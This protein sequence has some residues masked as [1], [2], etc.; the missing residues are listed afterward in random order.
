M[1]GIMNE[2]KICYKPEEIWDMRWFA[3]PFVVLLWLIPTLI[4]DDK[5]YKLVIVYSVVYLIAVTITEAYM[6]FKMTVVRYDEKRISWKWF[7]VKYDIDM[8]EVKSFSYA[9]KWYKHRKYRE[10]WAELRF[11]VGT[12]ENSWNYVC[13]RAIADNVYDKQANGIMGAEDSEISEI[14]NFLAVHYPEKAKGEVKYD[15][16]CM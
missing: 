11:K 12:G 16:Y 8:S 7:W 2:K 5:H 1:R 6:S 15:K 13:L 3:T 14:Y 9:F 10:I 4:L